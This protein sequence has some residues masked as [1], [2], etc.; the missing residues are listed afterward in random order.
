M[1]SNDQLSKNHQICLELLDKFLDVCNKNHV[2]YYLAFG[3]CLGTVRH[4]GFIPWDINVDVL[5]TVDE[6]N[7]LDS[8]MR[9]EDLGDM[10]WCKPGARI[11]SL[12]RKKDSWSD[13]TKPNIDVSVYGKAP[14]NKFFKWLVIKIA[15]F[16]IKMYKLKNTDVSRNFP[17][18][19]LKSIS[20]IIPNSI[21][22]FVISRLQTINRNGMAKSYFV[23]LPS[24]WGDRESINAEW[25]GVQPTYGTFEGRKVRIL[26]NYHDYLTQRYG[27][28]MTPTV[29]ENKGEYKH[30][31]K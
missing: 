4:H 15:Y 6:Y 29:W 13:K 17:Y 10:E 28:Y 21:Y 9:K 5:M 19:I 20:K 18:N 11:F 8:A 3:S 16:N 25:F 2:E 22:R 27:D 14:N 1:L 31:A 30:T 24:V 12:L 23:L 26:A 7:K